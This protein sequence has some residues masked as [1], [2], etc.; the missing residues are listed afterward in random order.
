MNKGERDE[1]LAVI[2]LVQMRDAS[3]T[4]PLIGKIASVGFNGKEYQSPPWPYG[5]GKPSLGITESDLN[6]AARSMGLQKAGRDD[7]ADVYVNGIGISLKSMRS[8]PPAKSWLRPSGSS[9]NRTPEVCTESCWR[10]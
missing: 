9:K 6:A 7:K 1:L 5:S 3:Q 4:L 10:R 2:R 8:A